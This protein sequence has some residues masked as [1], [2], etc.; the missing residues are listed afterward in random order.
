[1][2]IS[3]QAGVPE[4]LDACEAGIVD[5]FLTKKWA[6]RFAT[7]AAC[8]VLN[9]DQVRQIIIQIIIVVKFTAV[10]VCMCMFLLCR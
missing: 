2:E 7:T 5:L 6:I 8:T 4:C 1:M 9:V 3:F 10:R